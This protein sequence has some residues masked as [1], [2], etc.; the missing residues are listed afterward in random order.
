[1]SEGLTSSNSL[2]CLFDKETLKVYKDNLLIRTLKEN[3][4]LFVDTFAGLI[5]IVTEEGFYVELYNKEGQHSLVCKYY[6]KEKVYSY[7]F[8]KFFNRASKLNNNS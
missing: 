6:F 7:S 4:I 3:I 2:N 1:M 8:C 5:R